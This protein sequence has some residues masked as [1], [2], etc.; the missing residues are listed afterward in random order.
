MKKITMVVFL[1]L[2]FSA[3]IFLVSCG[4]ADEKAMEPIDELLAEI[5]EEE[6]LVY[7]GT[8]DI[9]EE[10]AFVKAEAEKIG[11]EYSVTIVD[12][13]GN[14]VEMSEQSFVVEEG[15]RYTITLFIKLNKVERTKAVTL[16]AAGTFT[17]TFDL[18]GGTG[19][20]EIPYVQQV[21]EED[22]AS[23]PSPPTK[24]GYIFDGWNPDPILN[25][26]TLNATYVATW[27]E[28]YEITF[29]TNGGSALSAISVYTGENRTMPAP[30]KEGYYFAG[31]YTDENLTSPF[32]LAT[33]SSDVLLYAAW[34]EYLGTP[35]Y[36]GQLIP[37]EAGSYNTYLFEY[38]ASSGPLNMELLEV[39]SPAGK[40]YTYIKGNDPDMSTGYG[41]LGITVK[42]GDVEIG[43]ITIFFH[44]TE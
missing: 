10:V 39:G 22:D 9:S 31:W 34:E 29:N 41:E 24:E 19:T 6:I 43:I 32:S 8:H 18:N 42:D 15:Q 26:I 30:E 25:D 38:P 13:D 7:V 16:R 33:V 12:K 17:I 1:L 14:S 11:A 5:P 20:G 28:T 27:L 23:L 37:E 21:I 40:E 44:A 36:S 3:T 4:Q 2:I 35:T